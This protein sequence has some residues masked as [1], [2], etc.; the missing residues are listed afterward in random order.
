M[1][2]SDFSGRSRNRDLTKPLI[3]ASEHELASQPQPFIPTSLR[4]FKGMS[5]LPLYLQ[6]LR[7]N[8]L[9]EQSTGNQFKA[10]IT[11][12]MAAWESEIACSIP[13]AVPALERI[14][15]MDSNEFMECMREG[16]LKNG[17]M[18]G[19]ILCSNNRFY[20]PDLARAMAT[21][22]NRFSEKQHQ[23]E[24]ARHKKE[25]QR[26]KI[27]PDEANATAPVLKLLAY[28]PNRDE[29]P[30]F[31]VVRPEMQNGKVRNPEDFNFVDS[32]EKLLERNPFDAE[33]MR[34]IGNEIFD[35]YD[36]D[37]EEDSEQR[38]HIVPGTKEYV[39]E[40][41]SECP[42]ERLNVLDHTLA[43]P[44]ENL[45]KVKGKEK[46]KVKDKE[47][48]IQ[49]GGKNTL[50][51]FDLTDDLVV[52]SLMARNT[53]ELRKSAINEAYSEVMLPNSVPKHCFR[54]FDVR[55]FWENLGELGFSDPV[56]NRMEFPESVIQDL[57]DLSVSK[58]VIDRAY[59]I[60]VQGYG[61]F[62]GQSV[63]LFKKILVNFVAGLGSVIHE[64]RFFSEEMAVKVLKLPIPTIQELD[65]IIKRDRREASTIIRMYCEEEE[66]L[67]KAIWAA[68]NIEKGRESVM[69]EK[70]GKS[71]FYNPLIHY[72][73][74]DK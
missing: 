42:E 25:C 49:Q 18:N 58:P 28:Q 46:D 50:Q 65:K 63:A 6:S 2:L 47:K 57:K 9:Y 64:L 3:V 21:T 16:Q 13:N 48:E 27:D 60:M 19:W 39:R 72:G 44:Q 55:K 41:H 22:M 40:T 4:S 23:A 37:Q 8:P 15:K 73:D 74:M 69:S 52:D 33:K 54:D 31:K 51:T 67:K 1:K 43:C 59:E 53:A 45:T 71:E 11:L 10:A 38:P 36:E 56:K 66:S 24:K 5:Y 14:L 29:L 34:S 32:W 20:H 35:S 7:E 62:P 68:S 70:P 17:F 26:N 61:R 12:Y 30:I